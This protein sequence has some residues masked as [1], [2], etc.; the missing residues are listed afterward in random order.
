M[1]RC[2][3]LELATPAQ[4]DRLWAELRTNQITLEDAK[5]LL[6][7][8]GILTNFQLDRMLTG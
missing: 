6:L 3:D 8:K 4:I 2:I 5:G 7:R 1:Q